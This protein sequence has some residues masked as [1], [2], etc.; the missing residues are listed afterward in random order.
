[1]YCMDLET[2]G[3]ATSVLIK[4]IQDTSKKGQAMKGTWDAIHVVEVKDAGKKKFSL[5]ANLY[6]YAF[7]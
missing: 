2:G 6:C 1:M 7:N 5:Q 3:F 4:K